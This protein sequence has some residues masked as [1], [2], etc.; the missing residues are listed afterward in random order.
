MPSY[1]I[2]PRCLTGSRCCCCSAAATL[3]EEGPTAHLA[4]ASRAP[5][6]DDERGEPALVLAVAA[7]QPAEHR[8]CSGQLGL[9]VAA[10]RRAG[11]TRSAC[12]ALAPRL[13]ASSS[14]TRAAMAP[15][16][17]L[18]RAAAA[19][20]TA[21]AALVPALLL[22]AAPRA[23]AARGLLQ[24]PGGF[25]PIPM[26]YSTEVRASSSVL[27]ARAC[28]RARAR[29]ASAALNACQCARQSE[30]DESVDARTPSR[31]R[32]L[33]WTLPRP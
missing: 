5:E 8:D 16:S 18:P 11:A 6:K 4:C 17:P 10:A 12:H 7:V 15:A 26:P 22:A 9:A 14:A 27:R 30:C 33:A 13:C 31:S 23:A 3:F 32:A 1:V 21:A 28:V 20:A 2:C 25:N 24:V 29:A 19:A